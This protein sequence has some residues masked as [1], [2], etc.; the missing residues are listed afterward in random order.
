MPR[1]GLP[2][3]IHKM[4]RVLQETFLNDHLHKK[5][6]PLQSST[7]QRIWNPPLRDLRPDIPENTK[8]PESEIGR[9]PQNSSI[10]VPRF[11]SGGGLLNHT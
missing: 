6:Y 9:E 5:D 3:V 1:S 2:R 11:Q 10:P 8:Q 4:V 7:I